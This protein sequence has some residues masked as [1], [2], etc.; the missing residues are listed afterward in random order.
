MKKPALSLG[1]KQ[2]FFISVILWSIYL[3]FT[4]TK[5]NYLFVNPYSSTK[6]AKA[7]AFH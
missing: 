3:R 5:S 1:T 2:A 6:L 4:Q 7:E